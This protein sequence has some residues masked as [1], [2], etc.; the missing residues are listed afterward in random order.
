MEKGLALVIEFLD[1]CGSTHIEICERIKLGIQK[2]PF[3]ICT[4]R[5]S[6]GIGSRG[7]EWIG[8]DGNLFLSFCMHKNDLS[9]DI[10]DSSISIYFSMIMKNFLENLGS[11]AWVKWPNDFYINDRKIGGTISTKISKIYIGSI[12]L[13][14]AKAPE[15]AGILDINISPN[16]LALGFIDELGKK[17]SWKQIFSKFSVEFVKSKNFITHIGESS[18]NLA[19]ATLCDDGAI[20]L[21][22]KKVYSLR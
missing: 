12:G 7:N 19:D 4:K 9:Q 17:I 21:N 16:N 22:N 15:N 1:E 18:V 2:P 13:N 3:A 14:L 5:Q 10:C 11:K 8:L 20:F 6:S